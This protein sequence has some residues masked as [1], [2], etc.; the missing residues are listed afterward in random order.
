MCQILKILFFFFKIEPMSSWLVWNFLYRPNYRSPTHRD[1]P[2]F[3]SP[4]LA[5]KVSHHTQ[6]VILSPLY[7]S[8]HSVTEGRM[9]IDLCLLLRARHRTEF[10]TPAPSCQEC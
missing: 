4:V 9:D 3:A 5:L 1:P 10:P 2:A 6:P 8:Y 7:S